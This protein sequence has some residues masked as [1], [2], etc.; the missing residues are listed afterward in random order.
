MYK[1]QL[2]ICDSIYRGREDF[3]YRIAVSEQPFITH[4][5]PL[6]GRQGTQTTAAVQGFNLPQ[7]Q[8]PLDTQT[9]PDS[10]R[11]TVYNNDKEYSN[12][13]VYAVDN[14]PECN[15]TESNNTIKDAQQIET[16]MIINGR[17]DTAGDLDIFSFKGR[18]GEKIVAE[19]Y[20]RRLNSPLDSVLRLTDQSGKVLAW[21]DDHMIKDSHLHKDTTG[22]VTHHA[23]SYLLTLSLIHI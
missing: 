13:I 15:E 22:L 6:G 4:I 21:N 12:S 3:I 17:I 1:R 9:G 16:P 7:T 23:D 2:E 8:L 5:F 11:H 20:A 14:L 10:I 19:V 18:A